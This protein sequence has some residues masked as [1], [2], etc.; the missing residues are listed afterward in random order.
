[1]P[2]IS[3]EEVKT[4]R[5]ALKKALPEF[6]LGVRRDNYSSVIVTVKKGPLD[7]SATPGINPYYWRDQ[8][9]DAGKKDLL[10]KIFTTIDATHPKVTESFDGDYGN[11]PNYYLHVQI[12]SW[13][14]PYQQ[15]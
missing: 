8:V 12:G 1:M 15:V 14:Q 6:K 3:T 11:I 7:L 9:E 2:Y 13:D 4:I 10:D 5:E